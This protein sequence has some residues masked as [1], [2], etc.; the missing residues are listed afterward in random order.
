MRPSGPQVA[1][2][3]EVDD[4][5]EFRG[6]AFVCGDEG[7]VGLKADAGL[8]LLADFDFVQWL[9]FRWDGAGGEVLF[10]FIHGEEV[11]QSQ[12]AQ[13]LNVAAAGMDDLEAPAGAFETIAQTAEHAHEGAVHAR[14]RNEVNDDALTSVG[15]DLLL[16]VGFQFTGV[17]VT[18]A[19]VNAQPYLAVLSACEDTGGCC[20][21]GGSKKPGGFR[22]RVMAQSNLLVRFGK[23]GNEPGGKYPPG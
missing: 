16:D 13:Q 21:H 12:A 18:A 23:S 3:H 17:L 10:V 19:S 4:V 15:F 8:L 7:F 9:H 22:V 1:A 11:I 6:V 2:A 20:C 5:A 14:T